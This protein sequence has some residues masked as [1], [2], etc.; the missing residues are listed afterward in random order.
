M[1]KYKYHP[2]LSFEI[3]AGNITPMVLISVILCLVF[4]LMLRDFSQTSMKQI[5][6]TSVEK[7]ASQLDSSLDVYASKVVSTKNLVQKHHEAEFAGEVVHSLM[8][9][10]P[11]EVAHY[12]ATQISRYEPEGFYVDSTDWEPESDWMPPCTV[13]TMVASTQKSTVEIEQARSMV[14]PSSAW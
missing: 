6:T 13:P 11:D 1:K 8:A 10:L 3:V 2:S 9:D 14:S 12:Y 4:S 5:T 7:L